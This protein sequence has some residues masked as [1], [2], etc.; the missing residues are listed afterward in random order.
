[1][2][3]FL[4]IKKAAG[5]VLKGMSLLG[6]LMMAHPATATADSLADNAAV[7]AG[8]HGE[9]GVPIDKVTPVIWGQNRDYILNQL[10]DFKSGR[11]KSDIM[12]GIVESL[13]WTDMQALALHFSKQKWPD[14]KQAAP[15]GDV[16]T[17]AHAA[18]DSM[19]CQECHQR[20]Y[21]GDTVRPRLSGQQSEYLEKTMKD[22]RDGARANYPGM[23]ALMRDMTDDQIKAVAEYLG[24]HP[25][26]VAQK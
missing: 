24:S 22:F 13:S 23:S 4:M 20:N 16:L 1:M 10:R 9:E 8:C 15:T 25:E 18:L 7:C 11:R 26:E 5:D 14:L 3:S 21:Q 19:N 6:L 12:S 2:G 17:A